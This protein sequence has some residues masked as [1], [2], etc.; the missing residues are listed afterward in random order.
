MNKK[1][2]FTLIELLVVIAIIAILAAILFPVFAQAREK[3]RQAVCMSNMK[4][5]GI[6]YAMYS[7]D[8][9]EIG[10]PMWSKNCLTA[11]GN[12][13]A[14]CAPGVYTGTPWG[15]YWPDLIYPYVKAG[16]ARTGTGGKL[17]H[18][19]Y[20][21]PTVEAFLF[22]LSESWGA[23]TGWG[24]VSLGITQSNVNDDGPAPE[25]SGGA[26][27]CGQSPGAQSDGFGCALGASE[28]KLTHPAET[29]MFTEGNVGLGP[30]YDGYYQGKPDPKVEEAQA[31]PATG[32]WP[33]GYSAQRPLEQASNAPSNLA[34]GN[35]AFSNLTVDGTNCYG[36]SGNCSDRAYRL[37]NNSGN[38][39]M[40]DAH[41]KTMH[42]TPMKLWTASS[43]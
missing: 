19:V 2:A 6:A 34:N 27:L 3:A 13:I 24:S 8:Y 23:S 29:I 41:V 36:I 39:L 30:F 31:Y 16:K 15:A 22:D 42:I 7:Q 28:A 4:Q 38:Y 11:D 21:C 5:I 32:N 14:G 20:S 25:G 9:D 43:E 33:A 10:A 12:A 26:Y 1:H 35:I 37:H 40:A 18:A 17:D